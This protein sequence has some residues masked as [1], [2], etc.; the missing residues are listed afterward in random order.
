MDVYFNRIKK[1][2]LIGSCLC[3]LLI[4]IL[5][6]YTRLSGAGLS[7]V[8]WKPITGIFPPITKNA[9]NIEFSKYKHSPEYNQVNTHFTINE[10]KKIFFIEY[11]HRLL[12]R[13]LLLYFLGFILFL[14][15]H[16]RLS[17]QEICF[18]TF[19]IFLIL[20]QGVFGWYMVKSGL[21]KNPNVSHY[22]LALHLFSAIG[23]FSLIFWKLL[24]FFNIKKIHNNNKINKILTCVIT[25]LLTIQILYGAFTAGLKAGYIYNLYPLVATF[26]PETVN[27]FQISMLTNEA[28]IVL[29]LHRILAIIVLFVSILLFIRELSKTTLI[30][31]LSI[32]IQF[33]I[34]II[35]LLY[36]VPVIMGIIHQ[37]WIFIIIMILLFFIKSSVKHNINTN[38]ENN[39][40]ERKLN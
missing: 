19:V 28:Y 36:S 40:V 15:Y 8:E 26:L 21:V 39:I 5:G 20:L 11:L 17:Y 29:F 10:F 6:S 31:M 32:V 7:I 22:R 4:V 14:I 34:G 33:L 23:I 16:R 13:L 35:T 24:S 37:G 9:W 30:L 1:I 3:I 25:F 18:S 2:W 38:Y 27:V 12:G